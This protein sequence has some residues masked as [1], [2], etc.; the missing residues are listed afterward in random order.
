MITDNALIAFECLHAINSNA[1]ER[2][3]FCVYKMDL[4]KAYDRVEWCFL[5]KALLKLGFQSTWVDR[6]MACVTSVRYTLRFNG[7]MTAPFTPTR[8]LR[9]G[10][11]LS[12][13]LFL[14][15][16]DGL[17][18][19][20]NN[21]V[22]TGAL[23][24]LKICRNAPGV[25]HLLFADD[26]LLFFRAVPEQAEAIKAMLQTY[27]RC[28]GQQINPTKC[29][30]M[31]REKG[32]AESQEQVCTILQIDKPVFDAKYLG[33]LTPLGRVKGTRFQHLKERLSKRLKDYTERNMSVAAKEV[34]IKAVAQALPT[35][36]MSV[37]KL[38]LG[39]CDDLTSIIRDFWWGTENGKRKTAWIAWEELLLKKCWGEWDLRIYVCLIKPCWLGRLGA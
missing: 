23:Q 2:S 12:P 32:Q 26:T 6:V 20:I 7:A 8:G 24:E 18:T 35:Y 21:R 31:F 28:T 38:P 29:S 17:S 5:H 22:S 9:Q 10:D 33:L 37:F 34:L 19:L 16:A 39:L 3:N 36:S 13:Y 15:V 30:I 25:S 14:F 4:S 11:P 1:D 27:G